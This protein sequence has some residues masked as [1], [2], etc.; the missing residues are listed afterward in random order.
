MKR[1]GPI[2]RKTPLKAKSRPKRKGRS[3]FP[4]RRDPD[5]MDWFRAQ[6]FRCG[7]WVC[8][9]PADP[10]HVVSQ[11][12]GGKD[13]GNVARLCRYHHQVQHQHGWQRILDEYGFDGA[14]DAKLVAE[15][16]E[17]AL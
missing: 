15:L 14:A 6:Q 10:A 5:F 4:K 12:A 1:S 16:Y 13:L 9:K 11:G 2:K 8:R 7:I 3:R 17:D